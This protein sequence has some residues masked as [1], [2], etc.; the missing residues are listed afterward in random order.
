MPWKRKEPVARE[1]ECA[2]PRMSELLRCDGKHVLKRA[3]EKKLVA[4]YASVDDLNPKP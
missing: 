3:D 1:G 4:D 2:L